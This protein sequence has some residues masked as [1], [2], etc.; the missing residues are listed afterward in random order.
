MFQ[1][2]YLCVLSQLKRNRGMCGGVG[3]KIFPLS[4]I[5]DTLEG[6]EVHLQLVC[7]LPIVFV[8]K[9]VHFETL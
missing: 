3:P 6:M 9:L 4:F 8:K 1:F 5:K 2:R 7:I